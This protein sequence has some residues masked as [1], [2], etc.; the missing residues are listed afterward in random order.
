MKKLRIANREQWAQPEGGII[1]YR[2]TGARTVSLE[3]NPVGPV[4]AYYVQGQGK[5]LEKT[6]L[7]VLDEPTEL[8]FMGDGDFAVQLEGE[9]WVRRDQTPIFVEADPELKP[10]TR[11]EKVGVYHD[12]IGM[13]LHRQ[14]TLQRLVDADGAAESSMRARRLEQTLE[15]TTRQLEELRE[16]FNR[17]EAQ[18]A[19]GAE[20]KADA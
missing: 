10:Y 1:L 12:E 7:A 14:A 9:A 2:G 11:F 15:T 4:V 20:P 13:A 17:R 8:I 5:K 3:I 18:L 19:A 16:A 6:L